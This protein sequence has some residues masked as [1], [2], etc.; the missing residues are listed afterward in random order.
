MVVCKPNL[1]WYFAHEA[2]DTLSEEPRAGVLLI[3]LGGD[4]AVE[5]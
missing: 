2:C 1:D 5:D 4:N 3:H